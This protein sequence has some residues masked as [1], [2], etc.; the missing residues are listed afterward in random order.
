MGTPSIAASMLDTY[1]L[2]TL[3]CGSRMSFRLL[4]H[5]RTG[6]LRMGRAVLIYGA[7]RAGVAVLR[8]L[9]SNP[10]LDRFAIGFLDDDRTKQGS[11]VSG[12]PVH[13]IGDLSKLT[14]G[15]QFVE[16]LLA[17]AKIPEERVRDITFRCSSVGIRVRRVAIEWQD[18]SLS[19]VSDSFQLAERA[20]P[21]TSID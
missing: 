4:D 6:S 21:T 20:S 3:I 19:V 10:G 7:G 17:S 18:V 11:R 14:E 9:R 15:N 1:F 8:E 2:G 16:L 13:G 12:L 5:A